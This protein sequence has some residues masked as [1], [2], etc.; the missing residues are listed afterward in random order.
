[1]EG[2]V[3][4]EL[5]L[6]LGYAP[7]LIACCEEYTGIEEI[8]TL[9]EFD[10]DIQV[11][12]LSKALFDGLTYQHVQGNFV[13]LFE[14]FEN[15]AKSIKG[16]TVLVE[17]IEK[18]GNLG[19]ILRTCDA[20]GVEQVLATESELDLFNPNVLRN[21][22]GA[23]FSTHVSFI[24]NEE[25]FALAERSSARIFCAALKDGAIPYLETKLD[26]EPLLLAF[27]A[28]S[29]GLSDYWVD[30]GEAVIIPMHGKVDSMNVSVSLAI[31]AAYFMNR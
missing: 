19:A 9:T 29:K 6:E 11:L 1:M 31:L 26:G 7:K 24:S 5:A 12:Q 22:R 27:G 15:Q 14:A 25:A 30:R 17:G 2:R 4:L 28:E 23:V 13:A 21:S 18:P 8:K 16:L 10:G 20:L 3:E